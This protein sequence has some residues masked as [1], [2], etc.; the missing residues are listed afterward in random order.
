[1]EKKNEGEENF[2]EGKIASPSGLDHSKNGT[3]QFEPLSPFQIHLC[4]FLQ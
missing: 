3:R 2:N 4:S 1:M